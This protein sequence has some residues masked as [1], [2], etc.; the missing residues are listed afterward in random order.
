VVF[1]DY[2]DTVS[3]GLRTLYVGGFGDVSLSSAS[4]SFASTV[5]AFKGPLDLDGLNGNFGFGFAVNAGM[6]LARRFGIGIQAGTGVVLAD[7][8]GTPFTGSSIR[9]QNFTTIGLFQ[10]VPFASGGLMKWGFAYDWLHDSYFTQLVMGQWRVKLAYELDPCREVGIWACIPDKG[11][12]ALLGDRQTGQTL[13][14]FGPV[15][16]GS[17]YYRR[18][19]ESGI[20]TTGWLGIA[21]EP[22]QIV[23]GSDARVPITCQ[24]ALVGSFNCI[25]PNISGEGGQDEELWAVSL[26]I[27][28][29]PRPRTNR[30][31]SASPYAPLFPL[32]NNGSFGV[33][34]Y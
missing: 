10:N 9:S 11:E 19:W 3:A 15:A 6:P 14:R 17:L 25:L 1:E 31:G 33:R 7:F 16:Q 8:H 18:C 27:E 24:L 23:L 21:G 20:T 32:A 2:Y 34:R 28:L 29:T 4:I 30:C 26:G 22:G 5:D 13:E 12:K